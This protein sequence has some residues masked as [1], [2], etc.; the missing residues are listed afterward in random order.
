MDHLTHLTL[1]EYI[2]FFLLGM[3][4]GTVGVGTLFLCAL[5]WAGRGVK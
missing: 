3:L 2:A 1:V 4:L 5:Y